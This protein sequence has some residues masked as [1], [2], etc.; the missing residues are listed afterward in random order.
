[1]RNKSGH[2]V[3]YRRMNPQ[4]GTSKAWHQIG[5]V[6]ANKRDA[7]AEADRLGR[8]NPHNQYTVDDYYEA[9]N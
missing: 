4:P 2:I 7:Y 8:Q 1:M 6:Y 5:G 3:K 9:C